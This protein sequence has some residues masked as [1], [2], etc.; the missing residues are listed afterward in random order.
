MRRCSTPPRTTTRQPRA[1]RTRTR[2]A[3]TVRG[4]LPRTNQFR[5]TRARPRATRTRQRVR[6]RQMEAT[7]SQ[8]QGVR[9]RRIAPHSTTLLMGP[10][11]G[12]METC[13]SR[14]AVGECMLPFSIGISLRSLGGASS[15]RNP[16]GMQASGATDPLGVERR[17]T[18]LQV[19]APLGELRVPGI[20]WGF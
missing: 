10:I 12:V 15:A 13:T 16:L 5:G 3:L 6:A 14:R 4:R 11:S 20:L 7:S 8:R 1:A 9:P 18:V 19:S 17:H 2:R